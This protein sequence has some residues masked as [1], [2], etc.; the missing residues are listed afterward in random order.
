MT[1]NMLLKSLVLSLLLTLAAIPA[2]A[3]SF[4]TDLSDLWWN[5]AESGWGANVIQ[6][7]E[8]LF[9]TFFVYGQNGQPT[10]YVGSATSYVSTNAEGALV[11]AGPLYQTT[12]PYF[13]GPFNPLAVTNLAVGTVTFTVSAVNAATLAYTVN[14]VAVSK[15]VTRTTWRVNSVAGNFYGGEIGTFFNCA[16]SNNNGFYE[17]PTSFGITQ[18]NGMVTMVSSYTTGNSACTYTGPYVQEGRMGSV[19][20]TFSCS[21]GASGTF[22]A[23]EIEASVSGIAMRAASKSNLCEFQGRF[24]GVRRGT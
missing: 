9:I 15:S 21:N 7:E 5:A 10:W 1:Q 16:S 20:G 3:T 19:T 11:F 23:I 24:G 14:G 17:V 4:S 18:A 2:R 6:Q 22:A 8:I 12:G 13:G